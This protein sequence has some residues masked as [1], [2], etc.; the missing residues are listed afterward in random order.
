MSANDPTQP[1]SAG[2]KTPMMDGAEPIEVLLAL[3]SSPLLALQR[4]GLAEILTANGANGQPVV[5]A[6]LNN[7]T[8]N[9]LVGI[10]PAP[11]T[12]D[13]SAD[14]TFGTQKMAPSAQDQPADGH[15]SDT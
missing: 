12:Q 1:N 3:V 15:L 10:L 7:A 14:A 2:S 6:V 4:Q 8:W 9:D 5:L 13:Q 11:S